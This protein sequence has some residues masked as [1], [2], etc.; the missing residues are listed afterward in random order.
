[1]INVGHIL[2]RP[3]FYFTFLIIHL[4]RKCLAFFIDNLL[5][6]FKVIGLYIYIICFEFTTILFILFV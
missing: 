1:M 3:L 6:F 2:T 4:D 5:V